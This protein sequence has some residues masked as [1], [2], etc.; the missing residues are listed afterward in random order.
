MR[1]IIKGE[2][3]YIAMSVSRRKPDPFTISKA[4][5]KVKDRN[6]N[7]VEESLCTI[8]N[9]EVFFLFDSTKDIYMKGHTYYAYFSVEIEGLPKVIMGIVP[10]IV[11]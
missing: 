4:T 6:E 2:R 9:T 10:I 5:Y 11:R 3:R 8:E 1:T 7:V